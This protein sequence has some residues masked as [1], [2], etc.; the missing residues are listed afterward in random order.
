MVTLAS[1]PFHCP[2][3]SADTGVG[4]L[5]KQIKE[6]GGKHVTKITDEVT[7]LVVTASRVLEKDAKGIN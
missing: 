6:N 1:T 4:E 2:R 3:G 7:H 5:A